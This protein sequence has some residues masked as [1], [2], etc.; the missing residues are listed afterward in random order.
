MQFSVVMSPLRSGALA[1]LLFVAALVLPN[2][3]VA[4]LPQTR[5]PIRRITNVAAHPFNLTVAAPAPIATCPAPTLAQ[6]KDINYLVSGCGQAH[7]KT[8]QGLLRPEYEAY[9]NALGGTANRPMFAPGKPTFFSNLKNGKYHG[10]APSRPVTKRLNAF[11]DQQRSLSIANLVDPKTYVPHPTWE[12]NG[13]AVESCDEY[14]YEKYY[15]WSRWEDAVRLCKEDYNCILDVAYAGSGPPAIANRTLV[16]KDGKAMPPDQ[17]LKPVVPKP[18]NPFFAR[19]ATFIG[20]AP[21]LPGLFTANVPSAVTLTELKT[22]FPQYAADFDQLKTLLEDGMVFYDTAPGAGVNEPYPNPW[23]FHSTMRTRTRNVTENEFEEFERRRKEFETWLDVALAPPARS[24]PTTVN[25]FMPPG[26]EVEIALGG[27]PFAR[28]N[29][30]NNDGMRSTRMA[31]F[32]TGLT[33]P[34]LLQQNVQNAAVRFAFTDPTGGLLGAPIPQTATT[35]QGGI[36]APNMQQTAVMATLAP[37]VSCPNPTI[38][39]YN[40]GAQRGMSQSDVDRA[41]QTEIAKHASCKLTNLTLAEWFRMKKAK[42][43]G[44]CNDRGGCG[45]LDLSSYACD[46]SPKMF[47]E[48]FA[49]APPDALAI[50]REQD[51]KFCKRWAY[52]TF[53]AIPAASKAGPEALETFLEQKRKELEKTLQRIP[54]KRNAQ[55]AFVGT[56]GEDYG[57]E[58]REG[59]L[60]SWSAGYKYDV[61]W[62]VKA[63]EFMTV[64]GQ[65]RPCSMEGNARAGFWISM[66]TPLDGILSES[67]SNTWNHAVDADAWVRANE[68]KNG[69]VRYETHLLIANQQIFA[70]PDPYVKYATYQSYSPTAPNDPKRY[71]SFKINHAYSSPVAQNRV[72]ILDPHLSVTVMAGPVPITGAAW[73]ELLYGA[74]FT[75]KAGVPDKCTQ[76]L[77]VF[78]AEIAFVPFLALDGAVSIGVGISGIASAGVKGALN[79]ITLTVPLTART[80]LSPGANNQMDLN[81]GVGAD[82]TLATLSGRLSLY[83]EFMLMEEEFELFRWGGLGPYK[84]PL[85]SLVAEKIPFFSLAA[86]VP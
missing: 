6:C 80:W 19:G 5:T 71:S 47:Y 79:L 20:V 76:D 30:W 25:Q 73:A 46:W 23:T 3:G 32:Q 26:T 35:S 64:Q 86:L 82:L 52:M 44:A 49:K 56:F 77:K 48:A 13:A 15:D 75:A 78:E 62:E 85:L 65:K 18:K 40:Q 22:K 53:P 27:D 81:F 41:N 60:D 7:Q 39:T 10:T 42:S 38:L 16:R 34:T 83:I 84:F 12:A 72:D 57:D 17:Q 14:A 24:I 28:T 21:S 61:G 31:R 55:G 50:K 63:N 66:T 51:H 43:E 9:Y 1:L 8:C 74:G 69:E 2:E 37:Q 70:D 29:L 54:Q 68:N 67:I 45:C 58:A 33:S 11:F 59:D 36:N 4:Q